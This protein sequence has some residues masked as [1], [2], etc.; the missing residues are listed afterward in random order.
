VG[1]CAKPLAHYAADNT[2]LISNIDAG[3]RNPVA[4][5]D[6]L[7]CG[8]ATFIMTADFIALGL[9]W[10]V[11]FLLSTTCHEAA[12]ALVAKWGGDQTAFRGGQVT[13]NPWPHIRREPFGMVIFPLITYGLSHWMMGWASAPYDPVWCRQYSRRAARMALA[14]PA[15][16]FTLA[17]LAGLAIQV[18]LHSQFFV[19]PDSIGFSSV[20]DAAAPG[21]AEGA[22]KFLSLLFSLNILLGSFNL[23]P[24]PPL[25][26]FNALPFLMSENG[27]RHFFDWADSVRAYSFI[28]LILSWR[29]FDS[30]F[31][32]IFGLAI[33]TL[34]R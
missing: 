12:H 1:C 22:A 8:C 2:N 7:T 24:L 29:L 13:L 9:L 10:Y 26:G 4:V 6:A 33:Q 16:N 5:I 17:I 11:V 19:A 3:Q 34:Y 20:V 32:P 23:I 28:G 18:G 30:M 25:D 15:A 27:A 14:G 31:Q 21:V